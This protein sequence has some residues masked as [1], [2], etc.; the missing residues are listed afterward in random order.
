[1]CYIYKRNISM[2]NKKISM[3]LH[4]HLTSG[5]GR[6]DNIIVNG[7]IYILDISRVL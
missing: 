4:N 6:G 3:I 5:K 7:K 2:M 1:M